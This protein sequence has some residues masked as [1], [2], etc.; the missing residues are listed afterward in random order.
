MI[1]KRKCKKCHREYLFQESG[2][3]VM[4][5]PNDPE[6]CP[7]CLHAINEAPESN[8]PRLK[9]GACSLSIP[10]LMLEGIT[11]IG[12]LTAACP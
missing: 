10:K 1:V 5:E 3:G 8:T 7:D 2:H 11:T 12:G 6:H 9:A 4:D